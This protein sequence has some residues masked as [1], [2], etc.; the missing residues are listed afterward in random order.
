MVPDR[1]LEDRK[2]SL[3]DL[4]LLQRSNLRFVELRLGLVRKLTARRARVEYGSLLAVLDDTYLMKDGGEGDGRQI[5]W[6]LDSTLRTTSNPTRSRL[7]FVS[8]SRLFETT[9]TVT[10]R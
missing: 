2:W 8:I 4:V 6:R 5:Q 10:R 9:K 1:L 7:Q 3:A